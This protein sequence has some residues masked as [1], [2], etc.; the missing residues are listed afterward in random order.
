MTRTLGF[1]GKDLQDIFVVTA[2]LIGGFS[3]FAEGVFGGFGSQD[4]FSSFS[5]SFKNLLLLGFGKSM[6]YNNV[7][8]DEKGFR[9]DGTGASA[10]LSPS[11]SRAA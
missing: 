8:N 1:A 10:A 11:P 9:F 2:L 7:V 6:T 3:S 4:M 5:S